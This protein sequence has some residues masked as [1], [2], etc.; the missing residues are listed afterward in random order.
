MAAKGA[1]FAYSAQSASSL[2]VSGRR[3]YLRQRRI[4]LFR[5]SMIC[6]IRCSMICFKDLQSL[7]LCATI[8]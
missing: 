1:G 5:C 7:G 2:L 6:F 4:P 3:E 8:Y